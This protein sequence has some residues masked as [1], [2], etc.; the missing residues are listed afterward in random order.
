MSTNAQPTYLYC[1]TAHFTIKK[2]RIL[3]RNF[4]L[5]AIL[6]CFTACSIDEVSTEVKI[7]KNLKVYFDSFQHEASLRG[8]NIDYAARGIIGRLHI[9][10]ESGVVGQCFYNAKSPNSVLIDIRYWNQLDSFHREFLIYHELGHCVLNREHL[11]TRSA[12]GHCLSIMHSS[13]DICEFVYNDSSRF[14]YLDELFTQ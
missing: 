14:Y 13:E 6:L 3:N 8:I 9:I 2:Y 5:F 7:D 1:V 10:N 4:L 12:S 11:D